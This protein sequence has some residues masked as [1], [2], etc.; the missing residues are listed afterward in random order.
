MGNKKNYREFLKAVVLA[1]A[2][3]MI[4]GCDGVYQANEPLVQDSFEGSSGDWHEFY[5]DGDSGGSV[6][7]SRDKLI[8][9]TDGGARYGVYHSKPVSGHFYV[10]AVFEA[11]EHVGLALIQAKDGRPNLD[12]YTILC[13]DTNDEGIVVVRVKRP[14]KTVWINVLDNTG[15]LRRATESSRRRP[16]QDADTY[17]HILTGKQYSVPFDRTNKRIRIFRDSGAG[18]FHFYYAVKKNIRGK[19]A[20]GWMEIAPSKDWASKNQEYYVAL[21]GCSDGKAVFDA[22]EVVPQTDSGQE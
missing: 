4:S 18:F 22:V 14:S 3:M 21:I 5:L 1:V 17:E 6:T 20:A 10:E 19:E 13:V 15:K 8:V 11:D 16:F 2:V 9:T 7:F 12:N